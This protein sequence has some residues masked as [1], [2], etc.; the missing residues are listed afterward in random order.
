MLS[1]AAYER[2]RRALREAY[3]LHSRGA[4]VESN[5]THRSK[6]EVWRYCLTARYLHLRFTSELDTSACNM[7]TP[8]CYR[9]NGALIPYLVKKEKRAARTLFSFWS[10]CGDS[11]S[12]PPVPE[13]GAL[14][15]ALHLEVFS[16]FLCVSLRCFSA[17]PVGLP[18]HRR[19]VA[20][21]RL[22]TLGSVRSLLR[23]VSL[24]KNNNQL[25]LARYYQL[26]YTS[27]CL[28][29]IP[30][31]RGFVNA[32][33]QNVLCIREASAGKNNSGSPDG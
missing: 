11:N 17:R 14:P 5:R 24:R 16:F 8:S 28:N 12:R 4:R 1:L 32:F 10:K 9:T 13:T 6:R 15:T 7:R 25:F 22:D 2:A 23:V 21:Y 27:N 31:G 33:W 26:R 3:E 18:L 30:Q 29:I 19:I 20:R